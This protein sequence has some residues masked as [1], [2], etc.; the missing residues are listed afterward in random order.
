MAIAILARFPA[1]RR[2]RFLEISVCYHDRLFAPPPPQQGRMW[3]GQGKHSGPDA[4]F[5]VRKTGFCCGKTRFY[6]GKQVFDTGKQAFLGGVIF[7]GEK[8]PEA[9]FVLRKT[10]L[11]FLKNKV[12]AS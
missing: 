9:G 11:F 12:F 10:C 8:P 4:G 2:C 3:G 5:L 7:A 1:Q 6:M